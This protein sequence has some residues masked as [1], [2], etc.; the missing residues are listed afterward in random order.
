MP[1]VY[2]I[3]KNFFSLKKFFKR[4]FQKN[5]ISTF[6]KENQ[7]FFK[8]PVD[9]SILLSLIIDNNDKYKIS[10]WINLDEG[11]YIKV[12]EKNLNSIIRYLFERYPY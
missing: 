4:F 12:T 9:M 11:F 7:I 3:S 10:P 5:D 8:N 1:S 2:L 6:S